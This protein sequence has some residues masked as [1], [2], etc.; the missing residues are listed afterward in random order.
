MPRLSLALAAALIVHAPLALAY[1]TEP[2][3]TVI[4][5]AFEEDAH[6]TGPGQVCE[7]PLTTALVAALGFA[8]LPADPATPILACAR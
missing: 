2:D 3:Q 5:V 7:Q 6:P 1:S 8:P 4:Q